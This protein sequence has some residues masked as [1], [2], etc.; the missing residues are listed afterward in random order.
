MGKKKDCF[1]IKANFRYPLTALCK[2][3]NE[4][5][6]RMRDYK[7]M[8]RYRIDEMDRR[9]EQISQRMDERIKHMDM[10]NEEML[11][12]FEDM[13]KARGVKED[14][15]RNLIDERVK[16]NQN[17]KADMIM[18]RYRIDEMDRRREQ[19]SQ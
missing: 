2:M 12:R 8:M 6:E 11:K 17:R 4:G 7:D 14:E 13:L 1:L 19:I 10:R 5:G 18:M 9:R 15:I 3:C 16:E